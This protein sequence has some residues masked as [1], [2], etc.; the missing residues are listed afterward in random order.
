VTRLRFISSAFLASPA[1]IISHA[2]ADARAIR[3]STCGSSCNLFL[4]GSAAPVRVRLEIQLPTTLVGYV[5][6]E[7]CRREIGMS[8]HFLNRSQVC[9]SLAKV[10]RKRMSEEVWMDA[11]GVEAGF[12][13]QLAEDQEGARACQR[14]PAGVQEQLGAVARVEVRPAAGEVAPERLRGVAADRDDPFLAALP[15]HSNE[16]VVEVDAGLLEPDRLGDAQP[17]AVEELDERLVAQ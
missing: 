14:P 9:S 16:P 12:L 4:R 5:G 2:A 1:L 15:D 11:V 8:E 7:L 3:S 17:R 13:G 10:G 6:V